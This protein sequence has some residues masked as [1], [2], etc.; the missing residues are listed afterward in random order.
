[1]ASCDKR[2]PVFFALDTGAGEM[3]PGEIEMCSYILSCTC[4]FYE[5]LCKN[6]GFYIIFS[7][8]RHSL[9]LMIFFI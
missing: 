6:A 8:A 7:C 5:V 9:E 1:M 4:F 2:R 3:I